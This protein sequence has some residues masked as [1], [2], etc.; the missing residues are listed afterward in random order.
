MEEPH[1]AN[2]HD[3]AVISGLGADIAYDTDR[4]VRWISRKPGSCSNAA[5]R[6][7]AVLGV[8]RRRREAADKLPADAALTDVTSASI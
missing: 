1:R 2:Y 3:E 4:V 7:V 8:M 6:R 5:S